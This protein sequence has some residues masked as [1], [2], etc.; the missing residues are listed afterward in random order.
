MQTPSQAGT[1]IVIGGA[2]KAN[3]D[4]VWQRI[5][6]EAGGAGAPIV[7][8]PTAAYEPER[9]GAQIVAALNRC[10]ARAEVVPIAPHLEG[11]DLQ[12]ALNDVNATIVIAA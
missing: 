5:V 11:V 3:S 8:F 1:V 2:L 10:G 6:D 7:V 9:T 4:A 12:A